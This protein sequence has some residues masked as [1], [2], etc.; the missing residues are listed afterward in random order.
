MNFGKYQIVQKIGEGSMGKVYLVT[1]PDKQEYFA[2]KVL[3]PDSNYE[4]RYHRFQR[5]FRSLTMLDHPYIV[6]VYDS[7]KE[8]NLHY[9]VMEYIEGKPLSTFLQ[10]HDQKFINLS[11]G[12]HIVDKIACALSYLHDRGIVHRDLKPSNIMVTTDHSIKLTDFGLVKILGIDESLMTET[13]TILGTVRYM[14]PEQAKGKKADARTDIYSLGVIFYNLVTGVLPFIDH[15]PI[16]LLLKIISDE[17]KSPA[18]INEQIPP[19]LSSIILKMLAKDPEDRFPSA[20]AV[21]NEF[22]K[23]R[24]YL[25]D[26]SESMDDA[27]SDEVTQ[28]I[29]KIKRDPEL[30]LK[31]HSEMETIKFTLESQYRERSDVL[32]DL[33]HYYHS[34]SEK[35]ELVAILGEEGGGKTRLVNEFE[36][37]LAKE[38][39]KVIYGRNLSGKE[40]SYQII[41]DLLTNFTQ[42]DSRAD[43]GP[44]HARDDENTEITESPSANRLFNKFT[45]SS[46]VSYPRELAKRKYR[47]WYQT[48]LLLQKH[49]ADTPLV[50]ILED[51]Q[52]GSLEEWQFLRYLLLSTQEW[53]AK[54]Q[55]KPRF[56]ILVTITHEEFL[57]SS[58]TLTYL[59]RLEKEGLLTK[60]YLKPFT[61]SQTEMF[62]HSLLGCT[63]TPPQLIQAIQEVSQGNPFFI[64]EI[65]Q[66][67]VRRQILLRR[68]NQVSLSTQNIEDVEQQEVILHTIP[69]NFYEI[70]NNF[71]ESMEQDLQ[72]ILKVAAVI[73]QQFD[74]NLVQQLSGISSDFLYRGFQKLLMHKII[75]EDPIQ[76]T[77]YLFRHPLL[78]EIIYTAIDLNDRSRLHR[79]LGELLTLKAENIQRSAG[80][81]ATHFEEGMDYLQAAQFFTTAGKYACFLKASSKGSGYFQEA[82]SNIDRHIESTTGSDQLATLHQIKANTLENAGLCRLFNGDL[83]QARQYFS[84]IEMISQKI[85]DNTLAAKS[86]NRLGEIYLIL[87]EHEK[88]RAHLLKAEEI[89]QAQTDLLELKRN[90]ELTG[91]LLA[92]TGEYDHSIKYLQKILQLQLSL[93]PDAVSFSRNMVLIAHVHLESENFDKAKE[94]YRRALNFLDE[95]VHQQFLFEPYRGLYKLH[96]LLDQQSDSDHFKE[97]LI[98]LCDEN[99]N[100]FELA[101]TFRCSAELYLKAGN[102]EASKKVREKAEKIIWILDDPAL[103]Q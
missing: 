85:G 49:S 6:K 48:S 95:E 91:Q 21:V 88:A 20:M 60:I 53:G 16:N 14:S 82:L 31:N 62:I 93:P 30:E 96:F 71:L 3:L 35:Q 75:I 86:Y 81:I 84:Q 97:R 42:S 68:N 101:L 24:L 63:E 100:L 41:T 4:T 64:E 89:F 37:E 40:E 56:F 44:K 65:I 83:N 25:D 70:V 67:L 13:G 46:D 76:E 17:P 2:L 28:K 94:Y 59:A 58:S 26:E 92:K 23:Q 38:H 10:Q 22:T 12:I 52:N 34:S 72:W 98:A 51:M 99:E 66:D 54:S 7:G 45:P 73:G 57:A 50:I 32:K 9:F 19:A 36:R 33:L 77:L 78:H 5:E 29:I 55:Q 27:D 18:E 74:F 47:F 80:I 43:A 8:K 11:T 90:Y 69:S 103:L 39:I 87:N 15:D 61:L 1:V 102:H 79:R